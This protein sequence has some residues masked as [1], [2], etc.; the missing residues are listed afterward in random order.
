MS[1]MSFKQAKEL[2]EQFELAE[3][4][5]G[6]TLKRIDR[7]SSN[8]DNSLA[9]QEEILRVIPQTDKKLN[10]MKLIVAVNIGFI[11]GLIVSK[12]LF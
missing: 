11:L 12:Y 7:A 5:L 1:D 8:F 10:T 2:T 9:K 3:L 4:T 6:Q